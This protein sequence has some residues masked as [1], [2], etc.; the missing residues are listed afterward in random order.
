MT[1]SN[2]WRIDYRYSCGEFWDIIFGHD[3]DSV[4]KLFRA[5]MSKRGI[6]SYDVIKVVKES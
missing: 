6:T 2:C 4:M 3:E 5:R 1:I